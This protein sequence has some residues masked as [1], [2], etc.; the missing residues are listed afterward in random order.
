MPQADIDALNESFR[1]PEIREQGTDSHVGLGNVNARLKFFY[2][3]AFGL[4][5]EANALDGLSI[6]IHIS[7]VP[8]QNMLERV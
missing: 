6:R 8:A 3:A 5:L 7:R 2:G 4:H 1:T